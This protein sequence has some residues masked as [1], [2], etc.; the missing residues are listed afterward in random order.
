MGK[1]GGG[2]A[3]RGRQA[4]KRDIGYV[5]SRTFPESGSV[6]MSQNHAFWAYGR[7][8]PSKK[9]IVQ[10]SRWENNLKEVTLV[11]E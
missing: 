7:Q 11:A 8:D 6:V 5:N 9:E 2:R 3:G 4:L 10:L 1:E